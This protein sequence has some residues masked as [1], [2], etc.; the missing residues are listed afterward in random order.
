MEN[1]SHIIWEGK[2]KRAK[3]LLESGYDINAF[4]GENKL[5]PIYSAMNADDP[6]SALNFV[7]E[8]GADIDILF[9]YPLHIAFDSLI[10]GML[11]NDWTEPHP[12]DIEMIKI[13]YNKGANLTIVDEEGL[14]PFSIISDYS[15]NFERFKEL[16]DLFLS[17]VPE[18][19]EHIKWKK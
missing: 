14:T 10:D 13:L 15:V 16:K 12:D 9:G 19:D 17:I 8:N 6:V 18:F 11:Q 2:L 7:I 5:L 4:Y 3:E 1:L